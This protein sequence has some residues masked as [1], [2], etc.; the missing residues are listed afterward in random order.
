MKNPTIGINSTKEFD[1]IIM[2]EV[3]P[4]IMKAYAVLGNTAEHSKNALL[5]AATERLKE[6]I[7][8]FCD[9]NRNAQYGFLKDTDDF[10][11]QI[12]QYLNI[13]KFRDTSASQLQ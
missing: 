5:F 11:K 6:C 13:A 4:A 12:E 8:E 7:T 2:S 9:E 1:R 10:N 3:Y